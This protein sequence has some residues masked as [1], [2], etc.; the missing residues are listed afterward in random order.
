MEIDVPPMPSR[1]LRISTEMLPERERFSALQE[2]FAQKILKMDLI[3]RGGQCPRIEVAFVPLGAVA[4]GAV[5]CTSAEFIRR[6]H[7]LKDCSDDFR[8]TIVAAGT[9]QF[10]HAGEEGICD[11]GW[12][13][14]VDQAR[15][16]R[17]FWPRDV[18]VRNVTV[19]A[20]A[21]KTLVAHPEDLAGRRVRP[22][23]VL[24][25][26]DGY[27]QSLTSLQE[28]PSLELAPSIGV[29]LLDLLA[30]VIGPTA[31]AA[32][33]IATRGL[34]AARTRAILA[35]IARRFGD[36]NTDLDDVA[37]A[38]GLSRRYVQ[39][40]LEETGKSFTEHLIERRL[41]RSFAMLTDRRYL[42][43]A[44]I[45]IALA[46]GFGDISHFNRVFR[47]HFGDTPSGVRAAA[48]RPK[49]K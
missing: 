28:P 4:A 8:L 13:H 26:L 16:H 44:I 2:E 17:A 35:Q 43:L 5:N 37:G 6:N 1:L 49:Q 40:L 19:Q 34:K 27:L 10:S 15:P 23:L 18:S 12:A 21:L 32:E 11:R 25:L 47:R 39:R 14:L 45:D 7:H 29:H 3:D 9:V 46:V 38:L 22:G 31:E 41:D 42:H 33:I 24:S 30:A 36:C 48:I 20:A